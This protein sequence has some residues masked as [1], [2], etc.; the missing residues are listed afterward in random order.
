MKYL[1][2]TPGIKIP[3][4][5]SHSKILIQLPKDPVLSQEM[6]I[7]LIYNADINHF[8]KKISE[9]YL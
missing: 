5:S 6:S 8:T 3:T 4:N 7:K 9:N 2:R 1:T